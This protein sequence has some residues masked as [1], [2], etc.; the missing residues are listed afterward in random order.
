[1]PVIYELRGKAAAFGELAINLYS[2]CAVGC[3]YCSDSW[4]RRMTWEKWTTRRTAAKEYSVSTRTRRKRNG[5]RS[6][7]DPDWPRAPTPINRTRRPG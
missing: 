4:V 7:R 5:G 2:G 3:R 1:M 6:A